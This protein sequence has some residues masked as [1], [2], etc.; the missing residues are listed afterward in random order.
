MV[1]R[2]DSYLID[3][4]VAE[5]RKELVVYGLDEAVGS[6]TLN[7]TRQHLQEA[8]EQAEPERADDVK[9]LLKQFG[10]PRAMAKALARES[11]ARRKGRFLWPC[12]GLL[13]LQLPFHM[14][15]PRV[16]GTT[17]WMGSAIL[18]TALAFMTVCGFLARRALFGQFLAFCL[19]LVAF[20]TTW[21]SATSYPMDMSLS[22]GYMYPVA[23]VEYSKRMAE[24]GARRERD[25]QVPKLME[26]GAAAFKAGKP[27]LI[28]ATFRYKDRYWLPEGVFEVFDYQLDPEWRSTL[29]TTDSFEKAKAGW[30]AKRYETETEPEWISKL[31]RQSAG[32]MQESMNYLAWIKDQPLS[33]QIPLHLKMTAAR[34]IPLCLI[35]LMFTNLGWGLWLV[36]RWMGRVRR[37]AM[38]A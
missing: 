25:L 27:A 5:L 34:A 30:V 32:T 19:G 14:I 4:Y 17:I 12:V 29:L 23:R 24:M 36:G 18:A 6:E 3:G 10:S 21:Y 16:P 15:L 35:S 7:E 9:A 22:A 20:W 38:L 26:A 2:V 28:P 31:A 1:E 33:V 8:V 37:R 13:A 11:M